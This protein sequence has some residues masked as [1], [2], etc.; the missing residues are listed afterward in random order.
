MSDTSDARKPSWLKPHGQPWGVSSSKPVYDNPWIAVTE[1]QAIAPTGRP[2][3]YGKV[4][5]KNQAIGV[6]PLHEDGTVTL[7]GQNRF[8]I[9]KYSWELPE[10]GAPLGEDPLDGAKRELAEEVGLVA[11]DWRPL[12]RLELSNSVTDEIGFGFLAMGLSP[13]PTAPDE[14]EDLA[15]ARVPFSEA[16]EAAVGGHMPDVLTVALLLR[17]HHMAVKGELPRD[18]ARLVL[19]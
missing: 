9:A 10:G 4:S 2:A 8:A 15:V 13:A 1:Y 16:L 3:L 17:V 12:L 19:G 5:F 6:V 18:L 7:V 14:T 11:S